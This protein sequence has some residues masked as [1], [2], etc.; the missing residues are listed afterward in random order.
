MKITAYLIAASILFGQSMSAMATET[1]SQLPEENT[2]KSEGT[3]KQDTD[4]TFGGNDA[5]DDGVPAE[6]TQESSEN[7]ETAGESASEEAAVQ[8]EDLKTAQD[9][10]LDIAEQKSILALV[11]L[12]NKYEVKDIPSKDGE[13]VVSVVSGQS[14]Q[15]EGVDLDKEGNV[16]YKVSLYQ[17]EK[18]YSGYIEKRYLATSD[19]DFLN[20]T[21]EYVE[22]EQISAYT[23]KTM[24]I[25]MLADYPDV[26]QFPASY[27]NALLALKQKYPNWIFVKMETGL[28]FNTAVSQELG[29]KSWISN[30]QPASW[31]DGAAAQ[32]GWSKASEGI[33]RYYMDPRNFLTETTIFQF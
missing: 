8:I 6:E 14:V 3:D 16:W 13:T 7:A 5:T 30:S 27:Q 20:W 31:R 1:Q 29:D 9:D 33:L 21:D 23:P 28:N 32:S 11:Y 22:K 19:E 25:L 17:K 18:N 10:L 12:C 24:S 4:V 26:N 2:Q 15:I